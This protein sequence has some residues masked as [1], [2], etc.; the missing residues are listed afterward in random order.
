MRQGLAI[1]VN[2]L[3]IEPYSRINPAV[4]LET[5][6][7]ALGDSTQHWMRVKMLAPMFVADLSLMDEEMFD[8]Q[9]LGHINIFWR[10]AA[11]RLISFSLAAWSRLTSWGGALTALPSAFF[12]CNSTALPGATYEADRP[13]NRRVCTNSCRPRPVRSPELPCPPDRPAATPRARPRR[14]QRLFNEFE[15]N[16]VL[17]F[18]PHAAELGYRLHS[19]HF[20][21]DIHAGKSQLLAL[22]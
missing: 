22:R 7:Q 20:G 19:W 6:D 12:H 8:A 17:D 1:P 5:P 15:S 9:T 21:Q 3:A 4:G 11:V 10:S 16:H 2:H 13:C 18:D 14:D